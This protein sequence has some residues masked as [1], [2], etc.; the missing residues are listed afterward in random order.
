[1]NFS[2]V[3]DDTNVFLSDAI[4][5]YKKVNG[6][7]YS[8]SQD[9]AVY[10]SLHSVNDVG[11]PAKPNVQ[12]MAGTPLTQNALIELMGSISD[13]Y[14][15]NMEL[16]PE[17]VLSFSP[18]HLIWWM[19]A[20]NKS[21][22]FRNKEIGTRSANTPTP[23]LLFII[24]GGQ[25]YIFAL[26]DN[27]RPNKDTILYHAPYFNVY[28]GGLICVGTAAIPKTL[29]TTKIP[30]WENAFFNSEFTHTNGNLRKVNY[31]DGEYS[32][33]KKM[34]DGDYKTFPTEFLVESSLTLGKAMASILKSRNS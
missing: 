5:I 19:P 1:M 24:S 11:T 28:D 16:L 6:S 23:S 29:S 17:N 14:T 20:G 21:I 27:T 33:W 12:I 9:Q 25:W 13:T 10:A 4:L 3:T 31:P 26:K 22:F 15:D 34:L 7:R 18:R 8:N 30:E 32:F 2:I